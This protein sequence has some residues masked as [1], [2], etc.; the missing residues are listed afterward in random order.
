MLEK[1]LKALSAKNPVLAQKLLSN[2]YENIEIVPAG[3]DDYNLIYHQIPLHNPEN[4]RQEALNIFSDIDNNENALIC[5]FGM[6]LG[7]LFKRVYLNSSGTIILYEPVLDVLRVTFEAVDLSQEIADGRV[8]IINQIE[9]IEPLFYSYMFD[10][11]RVVNLDSYRIIFPDIYD[12]VYHQLNNLFIDQRTNVQ[13]A[14]DIAGSYVSNI[15]YII[16]LPSVEVLENAFKQKAAL[17]VSAGPSLDNAIEAIKKYRDRVIL[18]A[19]GQAVKALHAADI[20]P[21]LVVMVDM[22]PFSHQIDCLGEAKKEINLLLQPSANSELYRTEASS[23]FV[24]FPESDFMTA[25]YAMQ[26]GIKTYPQSGTVSITS[27]YLARIIGANPIILIGQDLAYKGDQVYAKNSIYDSVRVDISDDDTVKAFIDEFDTSY[28]RVKVDILNSN[29]ELYERTIKVKGQDGEELYTINSYATF[30]TNYK[31]LAA[32][33]K[34]TNPDISLIN[35]SIGGAYLEG[36]EHKPL[37]DVLCDL[38]PLNINAHK[39]IK[40]L[41]DMNIPNREKVMKVNAAFK[42]LIT[43]LRNLKSDSNSVLKAVNRV[44]KELKISKNLTN[45]AIDLVKKLQKQDSEVRK[46]NQGNRM[47]LIYPFIQRELFEY[48]KLRDH[49]AVNDHEKF[50]NS[51]NAIEKFSQAMYAG[52]ERALESFK[53]LENFPIKEG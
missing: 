46:Y 25:W 45:K 50:I 22:L 41:Y 48:N 9:D 33:I 27:F 28:D 8:F 18:I 13:K 43:D 20:K 47:A 21:D 24:Y 31:E 16:Q 51:L 35:C 53:K 36:F 49:I 10:T 34:K 11:V 5:V 32:S 44:R 38:K 1:N 19:I 17:I 23:T 6:G 39:L 40:E 14:A 7:Y 29:R 30:I 4:P 3:S 42:K 12:Q 26:A 37:E 52:T 15:P 2:T